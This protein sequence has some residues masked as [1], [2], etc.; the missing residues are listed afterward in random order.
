MVWLTG[1]ITFD[2]FLD[3]NIAI[4]CGVYAGA[5]HNVTYR[6][7]ETSNFG[8]STLMKHDGC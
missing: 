7:H 3:A 4:L 5:L 6:R 1:K 2:L 8:L